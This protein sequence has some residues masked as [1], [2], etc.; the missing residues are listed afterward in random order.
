MGTTSTPS[1]M[2]RGKVR[3]GSLTSPTFLLSPHQPPIQ[4]KP[5]AKAHTTINSTSTNLSQGV[6]GKFTAPRQMLKTFSKQRDQI[7]P[8]ATSLATSAEQGKMYA[9]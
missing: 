5:P 1:S 2:A 6:Q 9:A 4:E 3:P 8:T 7:T